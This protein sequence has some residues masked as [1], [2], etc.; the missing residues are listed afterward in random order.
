MEVDLELNGIVKIVD[1]G[2]V[3]QYVVAADVIV[4]LENRVADEAELTVPSGHDAPAWSHAASSC[5]WD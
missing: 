3:A 2:L 5:R 4:V 1:V